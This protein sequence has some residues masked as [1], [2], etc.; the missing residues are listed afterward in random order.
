[1][2]RVFV[3]PLGERVG[4]YGLM[5][6][7]DGVL[8]ATA[9]HAAMA[10]RFDGALPQ[11]WAA[12]L[13]PAAVLVVVVRLVANAAARLH[14]WSFRL[15]GLPDAVRIATAATTGSVLI[16]T[17][18]PW[19]LAMPLP[20]TVYALEFFMSSSAFAVV[21][22]GPRVAAR[23][24]G[25]RVR[26]RS[27]A[28]PTLVVGVNFAA[29]LL[30]RDIVRSTQRQYDLVGFVGADPAEVGRRLDGKPILGVV[31]DLAAIIQRHRIR[32]VLLAIPRPAAASLR[33]IISVCASLRVQFKILPAFSSLAE[34]VSAAMLDDVAPEDLLPRPP[35]EFD[36]A[37]LQRLVA[38]RRAL[39]TGAGGSIGGEICRQLVHYGV[40]QL[41]MVDMNENELYLRARRIAEEAPEVDVRAEVADVREP[42]R[43]GWLGQRYRPEYVFHAAAHKHVPLM[44]DAPGEA[45]KNNVFGTLHVARMAD[46]CGARRFVLISTD[47]A[48]NPSSVMG[49]SKRAAELVVRDLARAS[50]TR[51]TAVRFGNVLGSAG[52]VVPLFKEQI[53]RGGPVTVTHPECTRYFM[54]IPEAVGLVLVAGLGDYGE[55]CVLDMGEPIRIDELA[56]LMIALSGHVAGGDVRIVYTGLRPG[57]KLAEELLTEEEEQTRAVRDRIRIA[58]PPP[59]PADL[60]ARLEALRALADANDPARL[61]AELQALVPSYQPHRA[62]VPEP[63]AAPAAAAAAARPRPAADA[64]PAAVREPKVVPTPAPAA[65]PA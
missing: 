64:A 54:T 58:T 60:G 36:R 42:E 11:A 30:A 48:V 50:R 6:G 13:W 8:A 28:A 7:L 10:L 52:S 51:M 49:A 1:M 25:E 4:R 5:L 35:V 57:E 34:P 55:L 65:A 24:W 12:E 26:R 37:E 15:A 56:R 2:P 31:K 59:P 29:E 38:G 27:G 9:L 39:V 23:W 33:K 21:R 47:K 17:V 14:A 18:A 20:R 22:F 61:V 63:V 32:V 41:V 46:A 43:I 19:A 40:R 53:A 62:P 45:V 3:D 16:V 44:E